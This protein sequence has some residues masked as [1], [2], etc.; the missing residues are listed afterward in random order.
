MQLTGANL[1]AGADASD[2]IQ[3]QAALDP[4]SNE[5]LAVEFVGATHDEMDRAL[6]AAARAMPSY[7]AAA[8]RA[9]ADQPMKRPA[10]H[11]RG[12]S[13]PIKTRLTQKGGW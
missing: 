8:P 13:Q 12:S 5:E 3:R 2:G 4:S 6:Q 11:T 9:R 7:N 10:A 1:I